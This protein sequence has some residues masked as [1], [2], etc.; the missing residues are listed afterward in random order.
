MAE[1]SDVKVFLTVLIIGTS[2]RR[3]QRER[4]ADPRHVNAGDDVKLALQTRIASAEC[5]LIL[6][7]WIALLDAST[8]D[9]VSEREGE[10][11]ETLCG[12]CTSEGVCACVCVCES[13]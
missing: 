10:R 2:P 6:F 12:V 11:R 5:T 1:L 4:E 8:S 3:M 13:L 7:S 9:R